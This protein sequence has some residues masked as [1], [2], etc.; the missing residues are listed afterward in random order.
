M[1]FTDGQSR[2]QGHWHLIGGSIYTRIYVFKEEIYMFEGYFEE[3][4]SL[5]D[6]TKFRLL[7]VYENQAVNQIKKLWNLFLEVYVT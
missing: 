6:G 7:W 1:A 3:Q 4:S 5:V 2:G